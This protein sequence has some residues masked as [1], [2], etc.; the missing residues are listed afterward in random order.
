MDSDSKKN[1]DDIMLYTKEIKL[2]KELDKCQTELK[3]H[4]CKTFFE[5]TYYDGNNFDTDHQ[6][7][8]VDDNEKTKCTKYKTINEVRD[9]V[10]AMI[11]F[12]EDDI[13][14]AVENTKTTMCGDEIYVLSKKERKYYAKMKYKDYELLSTENIIEQSLLI[15]RIIYHNWPFGIAN[16]IE[17]DIDL[18]VINKWS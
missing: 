18:N 11:K 14:K 5:I 7:Y 13:A 1:K 6:S 9:D 12:T 3:K 10:L 4:K 8:N 2:K 17:Y 16:V 15:S